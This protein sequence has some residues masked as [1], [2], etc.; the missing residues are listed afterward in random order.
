MPDIQNFAITLQGN[1]QQPI[2]NGDF[3]GANTFDLLAEI[4]LRTPEQQMIIANMLAL[5]LLYM[6]AGFPTGEP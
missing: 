3:T 6:K 5:K 4:K 1:T 2:P